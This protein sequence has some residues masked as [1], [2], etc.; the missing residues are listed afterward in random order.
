MATLAP[1]CLKNPRRSPRAQARCSA[2]IAAAAG[3][4]EATTEDISAHGCRVVSARLVR[5]GE[6]I[7]LV[8][9]YPALEAPLRVTGR[10][11]WTT[12]A[13][14]WRLGIAFDEATH[15]ES[16][17]WFSQLVSSGGFATPQR[18]PDRIPFLAV[19]Y[20]G[21]PP[22]FVLDVTSEEMAVLREIRAGVSVA[23]LVARF[24]G[25]QP[26]VERALFSLLAQRLVTLVRGVSVHPNAWSHVFAPQEFLQRQLVAARRPVKR[27][28]PPVTRVPAVVLAHSGPIAAGAAAAQQAGGTGCSP[29]F[30]AMVPPERWTH[31]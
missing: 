20:L 23:D 30:L 15:A 19:V 10:V 6:P 28:S 21:A 25:Q 8:L 9:T 4:F 22:R 14:P 16:S 3:K 18:V 29:V 27:S 26:L 17:R 7:H 31:E 5:K 1:K 11:V 13:A 24:P 12:E 2:S